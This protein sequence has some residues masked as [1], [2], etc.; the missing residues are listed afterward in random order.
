PRRRSCRARGDRRRGASP[1]RR[2][3]RSARRCSPAR[4]GL[5]AATRAG[6]A[7]RGD[8]RTGRARAARRPARSPSTSEVAEREGRDEVLLP[9]VDAVVA[10]DGVDVHEVEP[11]VRTRE[12][13]EVVLAGQVLALPERE[14]DLPLFRA[15]EVLR[16]EALDVIAD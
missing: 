1:R 11:E 13:E 10:E 3:R 14:R 6:A 9:E 15:L 12:L 8:R 5:A 7:P 2:R 16:L 4:R